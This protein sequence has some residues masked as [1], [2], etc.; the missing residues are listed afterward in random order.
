MAQTYSIP[1]FSSWWMIRS[2]RLYHAVFACMLHCARK[3]TTH[4][5]PF[6]SGPTQNDFASNTTLTKLQGLSIKC[7]LECLLLLETSV[8]QNSFKH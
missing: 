5:L 1:Q 4:T 7:F 6:V 3:T 8:T 2:S